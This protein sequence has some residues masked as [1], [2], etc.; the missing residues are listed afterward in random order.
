[1]KRHRSIS[2]R[3]RRNI[4]HPGG[5][6][7]YDSHQRAAEFHELAAHAHRAAMAHPEKEGHLTVHELMKQAMEHSGKAHEASVRAFEESQAAA[8]QQKQ[9]GAFC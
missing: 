1:M 5:I 4:R 9:S 3:R 2:V 8:K 7:P 6:L